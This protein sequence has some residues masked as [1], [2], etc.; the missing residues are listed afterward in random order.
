LRDYA[1]PE[2]W[3]FGLMWFVWDEPA[4]LQHQWT[5]PMQGAF[6]AMGSGGQY[7]AVVPAL[8]M[9]IAHKVDMDHYR[10]QVTPLQWNA[11]LNLVLA[12]SC[13]DNCPEPK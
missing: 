6:I 4:F 11:I 7:I 13:E 5:G 10:G 9:V 12:S 3:G 1:S 8:D 2:R